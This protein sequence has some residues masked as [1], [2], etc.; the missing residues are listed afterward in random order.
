MRNAVERLCR[1]ALEHRFASRKTEAKTIFIDR[2]LYSMPLAIG[3]R[4]ETIQDIPAA[5]PGSRFAVEG[6]TIRLFMQWGTGLPAQH[7]DMDLSCTI[8]YKSFVQSC[9]F[10]SLNVPGCKH[11]GDMRSIPAQVGT[12][13]YIEIDVEELRAKGAQQVIFTCNAYRS[14][15]GAITPNLVVGWMNSRFPMKI[16]GKTGVAYDPSCVQH[17]VRIINRLAKGLAFGS[18]DIAAGEIT[19][20]EMPFDGQTVES[21]NKAALNALLNKLGKKMSIGEALE[22]KAKAQGLQ[23]L[24]DEHADEVY[25]KKWALNTAGVMNLL[26]D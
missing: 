11:S 12:A 2:A 17:Q 16:S 14:A 25:S 5:L 3:D 9:A 15:S 21:M 26:M 10:H 23:L 24:T 4:N 6:S 22:I 18:L 8:I 7:L 20:L 1:I 13:E 19:W